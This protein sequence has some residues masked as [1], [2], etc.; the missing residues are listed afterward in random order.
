MLFTRRVLAGLTAIVAVVLG[1]GLA[2]AGPAAAADGVWN[3]YGN[4][5]PITSSA[6]TWTCGTTVTVAASV[7]AQSCI[8]VSPKRKSMQGAVIVRNN[9]SVLFEANASVSLYRPSGHQVKDTWKCPDSGVGKNSWSVCFGETITFPGS[10]RAEGTVNYLELPGS[11]M[12][13]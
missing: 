6:S 4:T 9:K 10:T 3:A 8:V 13:G 7:V 1:L 5:N 12:S 11:P 2:T